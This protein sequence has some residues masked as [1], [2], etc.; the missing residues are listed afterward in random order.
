MKIPPQS[1]EQWIAIAKEMEQKSDEEWARGSMEGYAS[2][3]AYN[4]AAQV[5]RQRAYAASMA[6]HPVA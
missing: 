1:A 3:G 2:A 5:A 6:G 4:A